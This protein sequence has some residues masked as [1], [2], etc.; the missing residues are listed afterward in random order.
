MYATPDQVRGVLT[1]DLTRPAGTAAELDDAALGAHIQSAQDTVDVY[2]AQR[3]GAPFQAGDVPGLVVDIT[4]AVAAYL[5]TLSHRQSV[6]VGP[7]EPV[8]LRNS[9]ALGLLVAL[10]KGTADLP[11]RPPPDPGQD[12]SGA[13]APIN[14]YVGALFT[15]D[16]F[17]LGY[18]RAGRGGYQG[19]DYGGGYGGGYVR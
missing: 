13:G 11:S 3:Y 6:E 18:S 9:W 1:R 16:D 5:A 19:Q 17:Y 4:I 15:G 12:Q 10:S 8:A 14:P 7:T 2:L